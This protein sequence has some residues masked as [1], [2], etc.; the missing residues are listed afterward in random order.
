MSTE[1]TQKDLS[2]S[3]LPS[4]EAGPG[5]SA[6]LIREGLPAEAFEW[7]KDELGLTVGTLGDIVHISRRTASR[8]KKEGRLKPDES[9]RVLRV[10]RIYQRAAEV[11]GSREE[12]REWLQEQNYALGEETPLQFADTE[13][14]A[15]RVRQLLGQI[16]HGIVS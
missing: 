5:E 3:Y 2:P 11:L 14:G 6:R 9:E 12:A 7:L 4:D 8:R 13:P 1:T 16:E 15:R 10:I